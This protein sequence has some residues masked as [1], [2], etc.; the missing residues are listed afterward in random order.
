MRT[1][2]K[3]LVSMQLSLKKSVLWNGLG[4]AKSTSP[5]PESPPSTS[6]SEGPQELQFVVPE[7]QT[8]VAAF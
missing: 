7:A 2:T 1:R 4:D 3:E 8:P 5:R 6:D